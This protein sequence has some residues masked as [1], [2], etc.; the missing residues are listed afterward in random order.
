MHP[1]R[2]LTLLL[3]TAAALAARETASLDAGWRFFQGHAP[4]AEQPAF[5]DAAWRTLDVPHDWSI[6]GPFDE[7]NP[8]R[9]AGAFLPSGVAWYRKTL[10]LPAG[11]AGRRV[12]VEFDGIMHN[13]DV[14]LNGAHLGHRPNG[15]VS[16]RYDLTPH[17][18]PGGPN[19]LVV[20]VDS[21]AQPASRWYSGAGI[22]RH[23]RLVVTDAVHL[24]GDA[25]FVTT[26]IISA[27]SAAVRVQTTVVN[28]SASA[29]ELSLAITLLAPDGKMIATAK[30]QS[31]PV[32]AGA[33]LD[34]SADLTVA[35]PQL[36]Q[37][38]RPALHRAVVRVVENKKSLDAETVSFGIRD[39]RFEAATGFWLNDK[40]LKL[41]GVCLHHDG[42]AFGAAVPPG[43]WEQRLATLRTLG[44]NAIRTAHNPPDPEFLGLCDRM[45]FLVMDEL[46][47][48][49]TV[50][51]NPHDY[52]LVFEEWAHR[53]V[54]DTVR[55]DR[56]HPSIILW[57]A[58]N[59]IHDTPKEEL[60]KKILAGLVPVFHA[61]D[62]TRP[63]TQALFRPN[64]SH[65][66]DNGLADL[67]DVIGTN[68]R[69]PELL[70]AQHAK[71]SRKIVGTEQGH[72][73]RIWLAARDNVS[74][75]G[76]FL[77]SGVDYLG[78]A[79]QWPT[80][81]ASSGLL[82]R[83]GAVKPMAYERQAWWSE[84]PVVHAVRRTAAT[85]AGPTDPGFTPLARRQVQFADWSPQ[86]RGPH[87]ENV[88][89]YSN[90]D[91]VELFLNGT[92]L[93]AQPL[94]ADASP[95]AW[96]VA[97]APGTLR[98]VAKNQGAV[99]ATDELRTAGAAAKIVLT[100]AATSRSDELM[101]V[102]ATITDATGVPV[103]A[104]ENLVSFSIGEAGA[105]AAVDSADQTSHEAFQAAER[106]AYRGSC[107]AWVRVATGSAR[108]TASAP[109]L[110]AGSVALGK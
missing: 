57:S 75:S 31:Q 27:A 95:R 13:S 14:W 88:E 77:W 99:V 48:C 6:A 108:L 58:G 7:K 12:F 16:L 17:L 83:T 30:T 18:R 25:T 82:D 104:A 26:P 39:A 37:L 105:I 79:R 28:Q 100:A 85:Q 32:A 84:T 52:H 46:F 2:H 81:G 67:L 110:E 72:E 50:A 94:P 76:Q 10:T 4:G 93:G 64:V 59:E 5:A 55:R 98:A 109:G 19:V 91:E 34:F 70:A 24:E 35:T 78:E 68:Y 15:Y 60:A 49:W 47:D 61:N 40:N 22:Y 38:D 80:V 53:D 62:P 8:A 43:I 21:S 11:A 97:F 29:R 54:R 89:V 56:N 51:K 20:R 33:S 71:P 3:L 74:H 45:G 1:L 90:C 42:G 9:G 44:V 73:R 106:R 102:T 96:K 36:W 103:P 41:K 101:R 63:V 87:E 86:N 65:D 69:D 107:V 66:Y 92:S 23:T